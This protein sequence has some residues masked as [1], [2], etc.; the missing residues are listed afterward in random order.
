MK[1]IINRGISG[2]GKSKSN[3]LHPDFKIISKDIYR[4][5]LVLHDTEINFWTTYRFFD[6]EIENSVIDLMNKDIQS[7]AD[8]GENIIIDNTNLSNNRTNELIKHLQ[9]LGYEILINNC[10]HSDNINDY[11]VNNKNRLDSVD[12]SVVN[13][14]YIMACINKLIPLKSHRI[15]IVDIDGTLAL[16]THRSIYD[17]NKAYSDDVN[18]YVYDLI[19]HLAKTDYVDYI[20]F[21]TGRESYSYDVTKNWLTA[22]GFDMNKHRLLSRK[23]NDSRKDYIIKEEIYFNCLQQNTVV[24]L[25]DD[26]PQVVEMWWDN[27]LPVFHVGDFRIKF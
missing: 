7:S 20:Q 22:K 16:P 18:S 15:L 11:I 2:S 21:L 26:R 12:S 1:A 3:S 8:A 24:G 4:K 17:Y 13:D 9:R 27:L 5:E 25:F 19:K 6:K 23:T 10:N 14:Q